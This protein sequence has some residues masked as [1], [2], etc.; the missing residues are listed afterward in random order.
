MPY[1]S[2]RGLTV[3]TAVIRSPY[4]AA[5]LAVDFNYSR[6]ELYHCHLCIVSHSPP[7]ACFFLFSRYSTACRSCSR[8]GFLSNV[9]F[10]CSVVCLFA[11]L[12]ME[13]ILSRWFAC[14]VG[15]STPS[16]V[17]FSFPTIFNHSVTPK[18]DRRRDLYSC[19]GL[20]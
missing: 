10:V 16:A 15:N 1:R 4:V 7:R 13:T 17:F 19:P 12:I 8:F 5:A 2:R 3:A 9:L 18:N 20:Q 11:G 6:T 14:P